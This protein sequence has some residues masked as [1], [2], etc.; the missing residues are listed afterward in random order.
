MITLKLEELSS[1]VLKWSKQFEEK[2]IVCLEGTLG[3]GKT[4]LVELFLKELG[5][6]EPVS[7][8]T[9]SLINQY[10]SEKRN[11]IA[12][13][14]LYRIDDDEDLDSIGFWDLFDRDQGL[15]FIEWSNRL[16]QDDLPLDWSVATIRIE[17]TDHDLERLYSVRI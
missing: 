15:I 6:T 5:V 8:P 14:D 2:Q 17:K 1:A 12:H 9:F 4:K 11:F 3:A 7:S 16:K 10:E 13:I